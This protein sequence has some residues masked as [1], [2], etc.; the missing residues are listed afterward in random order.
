MSIG[1][2]GMFSILALLSKYLDH[3]LKAAMDDKEYV[4]TDIAKR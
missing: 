2:A 1:F 4:Y 3:I